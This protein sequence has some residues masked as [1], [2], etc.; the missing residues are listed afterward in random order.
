MSPRKLRLVPDEVQM[1]ML[2]TVAAAVIDDDGKAQTY[3]VCAYHSHLVAKV[4]GVHPASE[5]SRVFSY[6]T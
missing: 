5:W 1:Q 2:K 6:E 3:F 4:R